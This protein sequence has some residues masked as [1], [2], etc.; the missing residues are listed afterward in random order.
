MADYN[1][2]LVAV[3]YAMS[4]IGSLMA[5]IVTRAALNGSADNRSRLLALAALCLGGVGIWSMHFI[6]MLALHLNEMEMNFNWW[7]TG[8]SLV[9][10]VVVV[11]IGLLVM[12]TSDLRLSKLIVAGIFVGCGVAG[13]HYTGMV[14]MQMQADVEWNGTIIASSIGIAVVASIV[15]LWLA[16]NVKQMWQIIVS[17]LVMGIA[18]CGMHYTGMAAAHFVPNLALPPVEPMTTTISFFTVTIATLDIMIVVV[19]M[20]A[21][22]LETNK[23]KFTYV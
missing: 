18:V 19:A 14:A 8:L 22:M 13:M 7:L 17:A 10:G 12:G 3:S 15:A 11:Y 1:F 5:L 20:V 21:A 6:G 16:V 9:V 2:S 23:R 4:V